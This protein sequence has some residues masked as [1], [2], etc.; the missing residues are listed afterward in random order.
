[1]L[2]FKKLSKKYQI[3]FYDQRT[4]GKSPG[5]PD[6]E[7]ITVEKFVSDLESIRVGLGFDKTTLIEH[8]WGA[9]LSMEY[10]IKYSNSLERLV[11]LSVSGSMDFMKQYAES[12]DRKTSK[13]NKIKI[14]QLEESE[15]FRKREPKTIETYY[16]I[17]IKPF[18]HDTSK[19]SRLNLSMNRRTAKNKSIIADLLMKELLA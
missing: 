3:I 17:S 8:S 11:L 12:I 4:T 16:S 15:S 1:M 19:S 2:P 14:K 7:S 6:S 10:A 9:R 13:E 18:F 5:E